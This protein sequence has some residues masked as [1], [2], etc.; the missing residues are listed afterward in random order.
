LR[1][2]SFFLNRLAFVYDDCETLK[3]PVRDYDVAEAVLNAL[4][5]D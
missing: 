3:Q 4:K 1:Q 2:A 5:L